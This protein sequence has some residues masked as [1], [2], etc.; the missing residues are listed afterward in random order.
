MKKRHHYIPRFYLNWFSDP[1]YENNVWVYDKDTGNVFNA[2]P[3]NIGCEKHYHTFVN[4]L[5]EKDTETIEKLYESV[6]TPAGALFKKLHNGSHLNDEDKAS[7]AMFATTMMVRVPNYRNN[8]EKVSAEV[9]DQMNKVLAADKD[10]YEKSYRRFQ[11]ATGTPEDIPVEELRQFVLGGEYTLTVD[12]QFSLA[13]SV[14]N[15][16]YL[17]GIFHKMKWIFIKA[18]DYKFL[19]S[20]NPLFYYDPTHDR[21]S[22]YGVGLANKNIEVTL[23]LSRKLCAIGGWELKSDYYTVQGKSETVKAINRRTVLS[24]LRYVFSSENSDALQRLVTK[25]KGSAPTLK[26]G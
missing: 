9:I 12:P 3:A 22:F 4:E 26:V 21:N 23:P 20:D 2:T 14:K 13:L 1:T 24:A 25:H 18:T 16:L 17:Y 11:K 10:A 19:T 15:I 7:F 8:I 5:G 6:E